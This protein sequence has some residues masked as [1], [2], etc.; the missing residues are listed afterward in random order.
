[1]RA[2]IA[3]FVVNTAWLA[4]QLH[5]TL[6]NGKSLDV[7]IVFSDE[8]AVALETGGGLQHALPLLGDAPFWLVNGDV[9]CDYRYPAYDLP[10]GMLAHLLLVPN[11]PHNLKG[12]FALEDGLILDADASLPSYTFAGI[13]VLHPELIRAANSDSD[14]FPLAPLLRA[15]ARNGKVSAEVYE[16]LWMDI[17]TAQRLAE[18]DA[19]LQNT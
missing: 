6:G 1:M 18:A 7:N 9:L 5:A 19:L 10:E 8:G 11:P 16:G 14:T 12:D 17:G 2:G 13:S 15:A 4:E 3:D